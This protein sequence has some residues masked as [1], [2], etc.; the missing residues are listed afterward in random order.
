PSLDGEV[1]LE[2]DCRDSVT[3]AF[4]RGKLDELRPGTELRATGVASVQYAP[5]VQTAN[6]A[7]PT[8]LD[9]LLR[10]G[11]DIAVLRAP[12]WWT[13]QRNSTALRGMLAVA[14]AALVWAVALRR[15]VARQTQQL[16]QEM[17][18]RRDAA[19]EFQAALRERTRLAANLHDTVL[20]TMTGIA[21]Q[22]EAC[23]SESLP[24]PQRE[25]NHLETARRMVQRGQEDLRNAV[26]AL[27]ALPLKERTFAEA[28]RTVAQQI[29]AGHEVEVSVE[30]ADDLP[31]LADFIAGNLLLIVQEAIH[32]ALKHAAPRKIR[33]S[34]AA[35]E[36]GERFSLT[37]Q[38][39]GVGFVSGAQPGAS[40]GHFG[41][42]GMRERAER[43]DGT[44]EVASQPGAG[45]RIH[46]EVPL[47]PF[48][49]DL[50]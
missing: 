31:P 36:G 26:W 40:A 34:L 1:R 44:M 43:L 32:N 4:L 30:S 47:R 22:I 19:V 14:V 38:D 35:V 6:F 41:L 33:V 16:A 15:T 17:R 21:Y 29:S 3:T 46:V 18:S 27:R 20:Q 8:R 49:H 5:E 28:V 9:L 37:I 42:V 13:P 50:A 11:R 10:D 12:S 48:D 45:T 2:L 25:A 39:D 24:E 23:E 7:R